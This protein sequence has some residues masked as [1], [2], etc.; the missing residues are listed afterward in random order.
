GAA[1]ATE[2]M[3]GTRG[4]ASFLSKATAVLGGLFMALALTLSLL[5][6]QT[7]GGPARS[8]IQQEFPSSGAPRPVVPEQ[9]VGPVPLQLEPPDETQGEMGDTQE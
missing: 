2:S 5:S 8:L 7:R 9:E 3:F 1:S 6:S 4:V